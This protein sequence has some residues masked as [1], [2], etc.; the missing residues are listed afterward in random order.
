MVTDGSE[1][2]GFQLFINIM[3]MFGV[4]R[5]RPNGLPNVIGT[6]VKNENDNDYI[7]ILTPVEHENGSYSLSPV[8]IIPNTNSGLYNLVEISNTFVELS[9]LSVDDLKIDKV[10]DMYLLSEND[11]KFMIRNDDPLNFSTINK[12]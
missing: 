1:N 12:N 8:C 7:M 2:I 11:I 3:Q 10:T 6:V 4:S 5:F 9:E